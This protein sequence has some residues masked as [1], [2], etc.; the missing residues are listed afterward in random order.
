MCVHVED[1]ESVGKV[2][3]SYFNMKVFGKKLHAL[4]KK[5]IVF[6]DV[7]WRGRPNW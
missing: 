7:G 5:Q 2:G 1:I 6:G 4:F 3:Y